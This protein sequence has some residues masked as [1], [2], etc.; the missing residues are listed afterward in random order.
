MHFV[1]ALFA[2]V[3]DSHAE[4]YWRFDVFIGGIR[5]LWLPG[6]PLL[7]AGASQFEGLAHHRPWFR[8]FHHHGVDSSMYLP[9]V[10]LGLFAS[11]LPL[12]TLTECLELLEGYGFAG[13][14]AMTLAMLDHMS[15]EIMQRDTFED[16]LQLLREEAK[17]L[18]APSPAELAAGT[19]AWLR[20][21]VQDLG[22]SYAAAVSEPTKIA[23]VDMQC[24]REESRVVVNGN[25]LKLPSLSEWVAQTTEKSASLVEFATTE[26][27]RH[28]SSAS[29]WLSR[30]SLCQCWSECWPSKTP[31]LPR[32]AAASAK[33]SYKSRASFRLADQKKARKSSMEERVGSSSM[34]MTMGS[35][36]ARAKQDDHA[37]E[38]AKRN[39]RRLT[40]APV[41]ESES[42]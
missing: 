17:E 19:R 18:F 30:F 6:F 29:S 22:A 16:I 10:W 41:L 42:P 25:V 38:R 31:E 2:A 20:T 40:W 27:E 28:T 1:A 7:R 26:F 32:E 35:E 11:W 34:T 21:V 15:N 33:P 4:A 12:Q 37:R 3:A 39:R 13:V 23:V 36:Q 24:Q 8:H 9:E 14:L 5:G